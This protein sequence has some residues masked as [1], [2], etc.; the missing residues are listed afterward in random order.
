MIDDQGRAYL[1]RQL[2]TSW[3]L[4]AFHLDGLGTEECLWRPAWEGPHVHRDTDGEWR[5][6]CPEHEGYDRADARFLYAARGRL[7]AC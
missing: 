3:K 1:L 2:D 7:N 4:M 6:D 5:A